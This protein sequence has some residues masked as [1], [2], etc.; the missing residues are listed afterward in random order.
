MTGFDTL[1][2]RPVSAVPAEGE[3]MWTGE[4]AVRR[5]DSLPTESYRL[6]IT[7]AGVTVHCSDDAGEFYHTRSELSIVD[8]RFCPVE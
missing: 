3:C 4:V 1:L 2:P 8:S 7:Q 6:E 5:T